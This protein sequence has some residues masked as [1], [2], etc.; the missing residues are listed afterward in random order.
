MAAKNNRETN[1]DNCT[2][3]GDAEKGA[4]TW[5]K[6]RGGLYRKWFELDAKAQ[7][8]LIWFRF[9][10]NRVAIELRMQKVGEGDF[11]VPRR[12]CQT[13]SVVNVAKKAS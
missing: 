9:Q 12:I 11:V 8:L 6:S 3:N 7:K 2:A 1:P 10:N 5:L 13:K 4:M